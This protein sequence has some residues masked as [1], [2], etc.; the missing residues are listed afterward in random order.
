MN[1]N[2]IGLTYGRIGLTHFRTAYTNDTIGL[3]HD[4]TVYTHDTVGLMH[5]TIG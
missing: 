5:D 4:W 3:T 2:L 1:D